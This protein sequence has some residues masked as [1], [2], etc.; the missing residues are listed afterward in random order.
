ML[1][2]QHRGKQPL[3]VKARNLLCYFANKE[4]GNEH[5]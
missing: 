3:R 1:F 5:R 4:L 2:I